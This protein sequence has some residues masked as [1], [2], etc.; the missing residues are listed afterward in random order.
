MCIPDKKSNF[1]AISIRHTGTPPTGA[2]VIPTE[3]VDHQNKNGVIIINH[4]VTLPRLVARVMDNRF[5]VIPPKHSRKEEKA[6]Q[7]DTLAHGRVITFL[8]AM[9]KLHPLLAKRKLQN[10]G[11][12]KKN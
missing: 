12:P 1:G 11:K 7:K 6:N 10:G 4:M 9:I 8:L 2:L 3:L 5:R